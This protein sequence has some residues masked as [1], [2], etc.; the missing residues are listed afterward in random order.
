[1]KNALNTLVG[2]ILILVSCGKE[3]E[4]LQQQ[5]AKVDPD[6]IVNTNLTIL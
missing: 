5:T 1:M 3:G 4:P 6:I 2:L